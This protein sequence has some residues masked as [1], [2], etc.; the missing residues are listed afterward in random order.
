[1]SSSASLLAVK[2]SL[3]EDYRL[4]QCAVP[5]VGEEELLV[6][7]LS[8]GI[9]AGDAK[10]YAGAPYFWGKSLFSRC[11]VRQGKHDAAMATH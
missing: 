5:E 6:K 1:M 3:P 9:C 7:V 2:F 10:C 11:V 8:V 4:E